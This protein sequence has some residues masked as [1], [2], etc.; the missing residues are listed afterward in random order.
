MR[1]YTNQEWRLAGILFV[2]Y[3]VASLIATLYVPSTTQLHPIFAIGLC[4]LFFGGIRLFPV[5]YIAALAA[6]ALAGE[7]TSLL[8]ILPLAATLQAVA[9]AYALRSFHIDPLFRRYRDISHLFLTTLLVSGIEPTLA[10]LTSILRSQPYSLADWGHDYIATAFCFL[11]LTPFI[12]RWFAKPQFSRNIAETF[13]TLAVFAVLIGISAALFVQGVQTIVGIPTVYLLLGPLLFIAL[14]LRPRFVTLALLLISGFAIANVLTEGAAATLSERLLGT[15]FFLI[16]IAAIFLILTS[17]KEEFR[18]NAGL[19]RSQLGTL[20]NA[21]ARVSSESK[22]K[23]DFIAILA[24]ELR[25]PLAAI[26][27][28]VELLQLKGPRDREDTETLEMI[29]ERMGFMQ[30]LLEDLLDTSRISEGKVVLKQKRVD[31]RVVLKAAVLS[32]EHHRHELHQQLVFQLPKNPL[33]V[34]GDSVR[35]EQIFSNLLTN[36]SKYS[37]SGDTVS[38]HIQQNG[39]VVEVGVGDNGVGLNPD[40][41]ESI[42]IPF[43]QLRQSERGNKGLG[44]GLA[45]VHSFVLMHGGSVTV[46]SPGAGLGSCFTVSLPLSNTEAPADTSSEV[47]EPRWGIPSNRRG[48]LVLVVDDN[49]TDSGNLGRLLQLEGCSVVYAYHYRQAI[50]QAEGLTPDIVFINIDGRD[51]DG[52][53]IAGALRQKGFAGHV[54]ALTESATKIPREPVAG[55]IFEQYLLKPVG[56]SELKHLLLELAHLAK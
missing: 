3:V 30:R 10:A 6:G 11:I 2:S 56:F 9:G 24:H 4:A 5:V 52:F 25:N 8:L 14:R 35:L 13:E 15:E 20:Q 36:A 26:L 17:V 29:T 22:A 42:F 16:A 1:L 18:V 12:L 55:D 50:E 44:I 32:T 23:N 37:S 48:A 43:H 41:L 7:S 27:L 40:A 31:L 38:I 33:W 53:A 46:T 39:T 47:R 54:V 28:G 34:M 19:M 45:L 49:D 21:V 51:Q